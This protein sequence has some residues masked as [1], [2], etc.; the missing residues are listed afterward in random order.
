MALSV[1]LKQKTKM[2]WHKQPASSN[3]QTPWICSSIKQQM[4]LSVVHEKGTKMC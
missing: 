1:V 2:C 4:A 3:R